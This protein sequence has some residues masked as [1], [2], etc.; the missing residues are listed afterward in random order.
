MGF[1]A[2]VIDI[3]G[4][5]AY[6]LWRFSRPKIKSEKLKQAIELDSFV[7]IH[8]RNRKKVIK[9]SERRTFGAGE[10]KQN[11]KNLT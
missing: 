9:T 5:S 1:V 11:D 3:S 10:I 2:K 8:S 6:L 4:L 7:L